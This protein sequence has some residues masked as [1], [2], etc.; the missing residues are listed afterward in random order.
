MWTHAED[1]TRCDRPGG[2][3]TVS[4][5]GRPRGAMPVKAQDLVRAGV[6]A[7]AL[8]IGVAVAN[9][10]GVALAE[11]SESG[12]S[13]SS[14]EPA[15]SA[16]SS[17]S[18][19]AVRGSSTASP[20]STISPDSAARS[21]PGPKSAIA[22]RSVDDQGS[23]NPSPSSDS[24]ADPRS[25]V[26]QTSGGAQRP[27]EFLVRC[28]TRRLI[29]ALGLCRFREARWSAPHRRAATPTRPLM[30]SPPKPWFP[31]APPP[32]RL[33][34]NR[35]RSRRPR[36]YPWRPPPGNQPQWPRPQSRWHR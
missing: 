13:T 19:S 26:V 3:S 24:T 29:R 12:S 36:S 34:S 25:G 32:P 1:T 15:S 31:S 16:P 35:P 6:V 11:T 17:A 30:R 2:H 33:Q 20:A 8:G 4:R 9:T 28:R 23:S 27:Y 21:V 5:A 14:S 7:V 18:G 10:P 22:L